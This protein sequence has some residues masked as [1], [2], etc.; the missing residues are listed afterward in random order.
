M[1]QGNSE[2]LIKLA[3]AAVKKTKTQLATDLSRYLA[4]AD[5]RNGAEFIN[6]VGLAPTLR[7]HF[8]VRMYLS[9]DC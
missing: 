8:E 6:E 3:G 9:R 1:A 5:P 7:M 2:D 4:I